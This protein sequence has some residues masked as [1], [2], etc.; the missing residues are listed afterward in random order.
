MCQ[1]RV[2]KFWTRVKGTGNPSKP[3]LIIRLNFLGVRGLLATLRVWP[4]WDLPAR[5]WG[6]L[7]DMTQNGCK[8]GPRWVHSD[9]VLSPKDH[10]EGFTRITLSM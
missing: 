4:A 7:S 5:Q 9:L 1:V 2:N 6:G 10:D 8:A 3:L